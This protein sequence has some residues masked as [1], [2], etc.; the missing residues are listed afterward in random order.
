MEID[1]IDVLG[2]SVAMIP[3]ANHNPPAR[4]VKG[5]SRAY[6]QG[7]GIYTANYLIRMDTDVSIL[8]YPQRPIVRSFIYDTLNVHPVG[9]NMVVAVMPYDGYNVEDSIVINKASIDRGLARSTKFRPYA[10][11]ELHYAG[12]LADEICVPDKDISGYRMEESYK[13]LEDDGIVFQKLI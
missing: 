8:H 11:T 3:F 7:L 4:L 9:Q 1:G 5:G 10:S 12:G 13:Y 6:R 2:I